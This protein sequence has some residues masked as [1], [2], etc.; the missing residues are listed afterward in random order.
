MSEKRKLSFELSSQQL[1]IKSLLN[2]EFIQ[3]EVWAIS[4]EY[5]N[6]NNS[7][8]TL[9]SLNE[10][11]KTV[12]NKPVLG[13]FGLKGK[14]DFD[15]HNGEINYDHETNLPFWDY[16]NGE[17]VLGV[18]RESDKVD[19]KQK[20]GHNWLVFSCCLWTYYN[21]KAVKNVLKNKTK[22]VSVEVEV[23]ESHIDENGIEVITKF[24]LLA[25]TILGNDV[26]EGIPNAHMS[27]LDKMEYAMFNKQVACLNF[28]YDKMK[29]QAQ[30]NKNI[31]QNGRTVAEIFGLSQSSDIQIN[32]EEV[33]SSDSENEKTEEI[34]MVKEG[35][36]VGMQ[37]TYEAKRELIEKFL[38]DNLK[39]SEQEDGCY[40][41]TW[42]SDLDD[43]LVYFNFNGSYYS[44][45]YSITEA[46]DG[47]EIVVDLEQKE[48]VV[49]SWA[50]FTEDTQ[51][52]ET[53]V[54]KEAEIETEPEEKEV[55]SK[56][57]PE[58][59]TT[60]SEDEPEEVEDPEKE[61]ETETCEK[62]TK[63]CDFV[64]IETP[65]IETEVDNA[66]ST[67]TTNVVQFVKVNNE[68]VDINTLLEKFNEVSTAF[69][70]KSNDF[71]ELNTKFNALQGNITAQNHQTMINFAENMINSEDGLNDEADS[72]VKTAMFEAVK[73]DV[74]AEKF[75]TIEDVEKFVTTQLAVALYTK[76]QAT[77]AEK[78]Q[79]EFSVT[80]PTV[81]SNVNNNVVKSDAEILKEA[82]KKLENI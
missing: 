23:E 4:D 2:K 38:R 58:E 73:A 77:K 59:K 57:V 70:T 50:K 28:A 8:F 5:P 68:D 71:D 7:H 51:V 14:P 74:E 63:E 6:R 55:E 3:T 10:G 52:E 54:E 13:A 48:Q 61:V 47:N 15:A 29:N 43:S 72:V 17:R 69:V 39:E 36:I 16:E 81:V 1:K 12:V 11:K 49:R 64:S 40:C 32:T 30:E 35:G 41:C 44:A 79:K 18:I 31:E 42:V 65:N 53:P 24:N 80:I 27:I 20:D 25:V 82:S 76:K 22:K 62:S 60:E 33:F 21:F 66:V 46:E 34:T 19:V 56:E 26:S 45:P 78:T 37:L 9:E 75:A 67:E